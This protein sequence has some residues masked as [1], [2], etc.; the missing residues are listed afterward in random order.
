MDGYEAAKRIRKTPAGKNT[1]LVALT[2]WGQE[3]DR[4]RTREA[5]F[6]KHLVKPV[7]LAVLSEVL[8]NAPDASA[9]APNSVEPNRG[10]ARGSAS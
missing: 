7:D 2:G 4:K 8:A 6:D 9:G 5:G 1:L 10:S 3:G